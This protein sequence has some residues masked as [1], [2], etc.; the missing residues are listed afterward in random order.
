[1]D[2]NAAS[3]N[4]LLLDL[5]LVSALPVGL[6]GRNYTQAVSAA[7]ALVCRTQS[8]T[9]KELKSLEY[10]V[11]PLLTLL[12]T[13]L[14]NPVALKSGAGLATL[15][16]SRICMDRFINYDGLKVIGGVLD[17]FLGANMIDLMNSSMQKQLTEYLFIIYREVA[18][19]YPSSLV[20][21]GALRHTVVLLRFGDLTLKT[22]SSATLTMLSGDEKICKLMFTH[23]V[24]KPLINAAES[25]DSNDPCILSSLGCI[26]QLC[27]NPFIGSKVVKQ[28]AISLLEHTLHRNSGMCIEAIREKALYA[29]AWL[30]RVP[31]VKAKITTN[32]ILKG[33]KRQLSTGT[34]DSKCTVIQMLLN[35]HN[36]YPQE[37]QFIIDVRDDIIKLLRDSPWHAKN[38]TIKAICILFKSNEDKMYLIDNGIIDI[39]FQLINEKSKELQEIPL[40]VMLSLLTHP[41]IPSIFIERKGI[42]VVAKLL[43]AIDDV[44]RELAI[45]ILKAFFLYN[46]VT[47]AA[48]IPVDVAH[49]MNKDTKIPD[50]YGFE[51]GGMIQ[52]YLQIILEN[53]RDQRY[54]LDQLTQDE[55][56]NLNL[57]DEEIESYENTFMELDF[58]AAGEL[59]EDEFKVLMIMLGEELDKDEL[60]EI[61]INADVNKSN[62]IDFKEF[63]L[64]MKNWTKRFG[65][66]SNVERLMNK[67]TNS[68]HIGKARKA[69]S[70]WWNKDATDK[71]EIAALKQRKKEAE[72]ERKA[73]AADFWVAEKIRLAR[74]DEIKKRK[75]QQK[76]SSR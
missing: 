63:V 54:L 13:D 27:K 11:G 55:L 64:L 5:S 59:G 46:R 17:I 75:V 43:Y 58:D 60:D 44:I 69:F 42:D 70:T 74:D 62:T 3:I 28:G 24:I 68:G 30:S 33:M 23:G 18:R 2:N 76:A 19:Y 16:T 45:I 36:N 35:L 67:V 48:A 15:M 49:L 65:D 4:D 26:V 22:L 21:V 56:L 34:M 8:M 41:Q 9:S 39:L 66:G 53:R 61:Y 57:S 37:K 52:E 7:N 1:M 71:Q 12:V 38:T 10:T 72:D 40:V 31:D 25:T 20:S 6:D 47:V 29:L 51:Y 73:L 14:S 32:V 50:M